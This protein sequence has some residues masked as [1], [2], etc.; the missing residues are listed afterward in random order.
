[1]T[2]EFEAY[3]RKALGGG[4]ARYGEAGREIHG[5]PAGLVM[6]IEFELNGQPFMALNGGPA[7]QFNE[8]ISFQVH[9]ETQDEIDYYWAGLSEGS[10][11]QA[12]QCGW[13]KDKHGVSWQVVPTVLS[14]MFSGKSKENSER[15]MQALL[16]MKKI[17]ISA[18]EKAYE[19]R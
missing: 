14:K 9:C 19:G 11:P 12:Q 10:D 17:N 3:V 7:F 4:D 5:Q 1:M 2:A 8:A 18:L 16:T 6:S 15:V 13:L